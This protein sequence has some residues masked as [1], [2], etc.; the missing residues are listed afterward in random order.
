MVT[1]LEL[2]SVPTNTSIEYLLSHVTTLTGET[3]HHIMA[4]GM[5]TPCGYVIFGARMLPMEPVE[6]QLCKSCARIVKA[7]R[8]R[9]E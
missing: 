1:K 9:K 7:L 5:T 8:L 3:Y 4:D 6:A 2:R